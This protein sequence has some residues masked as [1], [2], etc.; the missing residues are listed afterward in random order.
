MRCCVFLRIATD[1][2]DE[3]CVGAGVA[4]LRAYHDASASA[5]RFALVTGKT[6]V[7]RSSG[8]FRINICK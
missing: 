3:Q 1:E 6:A 8:T 4:A 5:L 7:A 2:Q